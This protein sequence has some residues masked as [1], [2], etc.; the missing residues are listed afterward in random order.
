[1]KRTTAAWFSLAVLVLVIAG[2]GFSLAR[3]DRLDGEP[4]L[5]LVLN[6]PA[7]RLYVYENGEQT[8][9]YRVSV[10]MPG[11]Q[12][13]AGSY[14]IRSVIW[15]PW[16]HPPRSEW[17]RDRKPEPPGETNPM[18]RVKLNFAP[19]L[20]IHGTVERDLL[21]D[22]ASH[23]CVRMINED[24][25]ELTR[26]VH[27]HLTPKLAEATLAELEASPTMTRTFNLPRSVPFEVVYQVATVRD[28]FLVIYPDVYERV[29][30][31]STKVTQ[32]LEREGVDMGRVNWDRLDPLLEKGRHTKV[33]ISMDELLSVGAPAGSDGAAPRR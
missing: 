14:A 22:P 8:R 1:M 32:V 33:A 24:L 7:H 12:T 4:P 21:G 6:V 31:Y 19:L 29:S 10:G 30:D 17:A 15:N 25:I 26:L 2:A 28:G 11:Y 13:P 23:G 16:W 9:V 18:G 3:Q 27:G 5:R 20:Y